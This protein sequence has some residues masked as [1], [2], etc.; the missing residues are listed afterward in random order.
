MKKE[1]T[2]LIA[3]TL[4][5]CAGILLAPIFSPSIVSHV[6]YTVYST[7]C[8]QFN[9]RSFHLHG[10][11]LAVCIRCSAIYGGFLAALLVVRFSA[12]VRKQ[13]HGSL[14]ILTMRSILWISIIPIAID[15]LLSFTHFYEP[16]TISR[17]ITGGLFGVGLALVLHVPLTE[18]IHS[19]L[20]H[21]QNGYGQQTR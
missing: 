9:S 11:P 21:I 12:V 2:I 8:H 7:V 15:G 5:W 3:G 10:E 13:R 17:L 20:K 4:L 14:F 19:T 6:L 16:T 18:L 1:L